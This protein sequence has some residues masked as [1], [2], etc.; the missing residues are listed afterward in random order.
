M[1]V[2]AK[3]CRLF[4]EMALSPRC[5]KKMDH[6]CPWINSCVGH[7]NHASFTRFVFYV[8]FGCFHG[9]FMNCNFIYR[10]ITYVS[11]IPSSANIIY[12]TCM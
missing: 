2:V 9:A 7:D 11:D 1:K 10:M 12:C 6:H 8:P 4:M 3:M 5:V